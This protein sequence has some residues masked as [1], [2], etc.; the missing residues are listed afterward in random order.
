MSVMIHRVYA[1]VCVKEG[2]GKCNSTAGTSRDLRGKAYLVAKKLPS[3]PPPPRRGGTNMAVWH[4]NLMQIFGEERKTTVE[5]EDVQRPRPE[6]P[7]LRVVFVF[8]REQTPAE[9]AHTHART[10]D[11]RAGV[12]K[13]KR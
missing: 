7:P 8:T 9:H 1:H 4:Q 10:L 6:E 12:G 5:N 11:M 2:S 3:L 13:A